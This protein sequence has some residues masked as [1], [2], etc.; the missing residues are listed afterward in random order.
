MYFKATVDNGCI[1][2]PEELLMFFDDGDEVEVKPFDRAPAERE[3]GDDDEMAMHQ[4]Y[5]LSEE[6]E[7]ELERRAAA[8][9]MRKMTIEDMRAFF[10]ALEL[11]PEDAKYDREELHRRGESLS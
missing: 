2:I 3:T 7:R 11:D 4:R 8:T 1:K 10:N 5:A 9:E 6:A